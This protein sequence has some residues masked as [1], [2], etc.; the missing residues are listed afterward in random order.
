MRVHVIQRVARDGDNNYLTPPND[1]FASP[2][3]NEDVQ[4]LNCL[5]QLSFRAFQGNGNPNHPLSK[6]G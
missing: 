3:E 6:I 2:T 5:F 4:H 1:T